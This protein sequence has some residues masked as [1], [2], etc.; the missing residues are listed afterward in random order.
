MQI[1][2]I[3]SEVEVDF[4]VFVIYSNG[5]HL[6]FLTR[7]NFTILKPCSLIMLHVKLDNNWFSGFRE[8][9]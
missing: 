3:G 7:P 8:V 1:L 6:G 2:P 4:V 9:V 5:G